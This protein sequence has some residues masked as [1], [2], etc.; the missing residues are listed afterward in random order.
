M[1]DLV[2]PG[3]HTTDPTDAAAPLNPARPRAGGGPRRL[4][5]LGMLRAFEAAARL[6][7]VTRAAEELHVTQSAVSHQIKALEQ[8]LG[9]ALVRRD[10][11][12]LALTAAGTELLPGLS[13]GFDLLARATAG[14]ERPTLR[15]GLAVNALPSLASQWL[16]PRL[17]AFC[18]RV[19]GVDVQIATTITSLDFEPAAF[20]VSLRCLTPE[21]LAMLQ[22]RP[23]WRGTRLGAFLPEALTP[24]CS[25]AW[26]QRAP[27]LRRPADLARHTWLISRSTPLA[28]REWQAAAGVGPLQAAGELVFDHAHVAVQAAVQG[29]GVAMGNA[30]MLGDALDSGLL[31]AP[32]PDLRAQGKQYH[33]ILPPRSAD[34]AAA[35]AFCRWLED[36]RPAAS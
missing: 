5:P 36:S 7:S 17:Q 15:H 24:V 8:W 9:L 23:A 11:R 10:G 28:W 14:L 21:E 26:L 2:S 3:P 1:N 35:L 19:P 4:P 31:V 27:R 32:F 20:D 30:A 6:G 25:P 16:I 33:W 12:R 29:L 34:N 13:S 22:A 18:A